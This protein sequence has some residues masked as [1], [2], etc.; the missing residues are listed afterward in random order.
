MAY[1]VTGGTG[2]IGKFLIQELLKR[3]EPIYVLVREQS[4]HKLAYFEKHDPNQRIKPVVGNICDS[5]FGLS[6]KQ[7]KELQNQISHFYHLA[8]IYDLQT[9]AASQQKANV[10]GTQ[11]AV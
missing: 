1:F 6:D 4:L 11:H 9:D 7:Y 10:D 3:E 2:F 5:Q 8:A